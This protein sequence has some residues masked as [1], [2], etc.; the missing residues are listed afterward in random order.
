MAYKAEVTVTYLDEELNLKTHVATATLHD[1]VPEELGGI[2]YQE[3]KHVAAQQAIS[4][5]M[6]DRILVPVKDEDNHDAEYRVVPKEDISA[7][8]VKV[9]KT[10]D[11]K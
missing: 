2:S 10:L 3:Y 8:S 4:H 9:V 11:V 7:I 5:Y 1:N 6:A